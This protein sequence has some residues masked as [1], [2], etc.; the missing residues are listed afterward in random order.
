MFENK[1]SFQLK[2]KNSASSRPPTYKQEESRPDMQPPL[3]HKLDSRSVF[4]FLERGM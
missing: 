3:G 1:I 4:A 2:P